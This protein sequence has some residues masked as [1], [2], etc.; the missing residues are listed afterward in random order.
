MAERLHNNATALLGENIDNRRILDC[1][2][3]DLEDVIK[4]EPA[5][6][7][8]SN[9]ARLISRETRDEE[10]K[11]ENETVKIHYIREQYS[12]PCGNWERENGNKAQR[13]KL[14][15]VYTTAWEYL[16]T[17]AS[18]W[19]KLAVVA[20][21]CAALYQNLM[22][23]MAT[24]FPDQKINYCLMGVKS[25][26]I[27]DPSITSSS[28]YNGNHGPRLGRL[29]LPQTPGYSAAWC[30]KTN[31]IGHWIQVDFGK[32]LSITGVV[33]QGRRDSDQWVKSF[34]VSCGNSTDAMKFI[35][36]QGNEQVFNANKD[37]N[38][39]VITVFPDVLI[40]RFIR[41]H[42]QEWQGHISMRLD[43]LKGACRPWF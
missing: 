36:K 28:E 4:L 7:K 35:V 40:C 17:I 6:L 39:K 26:K 33:T 18:S 34:K 42:P 20:A 43:F 13:G 41:V 19:P 10:I 8:S 5:S 2:K 24:G 25:G 9:G 22:T 23:F 12:C 30:A 14:F 3:R 1:N 32:P 31:V 15:N 11:R 21:I 27:L 29:D 37:R 38:S 16:A